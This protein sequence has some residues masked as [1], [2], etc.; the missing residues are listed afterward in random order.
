MKD[1]HPDEFEWIASLEP[2]TRGDPRALA[3]KDDAAVV[4]ARPDFDLVVST[5]AMVEGV[6]FLAG[7]EPGLIAQR[8]LRAALSDLAAK[9]AE[10]FGFLLTTAWPPDRDRRWRA[11]FAAGLAADGERFG[12]ALLGGDTVSTPGPLTLDA[13]VYGWVPAGTAV[14][15]SGAR[16]GDRLIVCG[17]IGDGVLGLR[18]ARGEI[19]GPTEELAKRYRLPEPLFLLTPLLR[20]KARAAADVSDGLL[21]DAAHIAEASGLAVTIELEALP[22][23][24]GARCWL[25]D[26]PDRA[27]ALGDLAGGGDDYAIACAVDPAEADAFVRAA[28]KV[29]RT[30]EVG[31]FE[32]GAGVCAT[33]SGAAV[34]PERLGWRN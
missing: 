19:T 30:A 18:A 4:P 6:H 26:Q 28:S 21:A 22:L 16:A 12:V 20:E 1:Q 15:R 3:L 27:A 33:V 25:E 13:A 7:E 31:V 10:P 24:E 14:L 29:V 9:A 5:D 34:S 8:L 32:A 17:A 2:L 11:A 23:S